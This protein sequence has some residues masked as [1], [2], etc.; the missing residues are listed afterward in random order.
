MFTLV[1]FIGSA[2]LIVSLPACNAIYDYHP[3]S[4]KQLQVPS[5]SPKETPVEV[6]LVG[7]LPDTCW[8]VGGIETKVDQANRRVWIAATRKLSTLE[9]GP[10]ALR[11]DYP[12][13][14]TSFVPE[15]AGTYLIASAGATA[16][17]RVTE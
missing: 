13:L 7:V 10:C 8:S 4:V 16:E 3:M 6:T 15:H 12:V 1:R 5:T 2:S 14:K 17:I 11:P 9:G